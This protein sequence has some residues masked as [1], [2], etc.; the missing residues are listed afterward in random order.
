MTKFSWKIVLDSSTKL[1]K[2]RLHYNLP[3]LVIQLYAKA[4]I[5]SV[6][7][8]ALLMHSKVHNKCSAT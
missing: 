5:R 7:H 6:Q 1:L 2:S 4:K 8:L 3:Y